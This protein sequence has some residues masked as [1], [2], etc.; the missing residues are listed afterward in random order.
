MTN[1]KSRHD[2]KIST[3]EPKI[4]ELEAK[5]S[6]LIQGWQRTQADFVN[7][8]KRT[9][10]DKERLRQNAKIDTILKILPVVDNFRLSTQHLPAELKN[11]SWAEGITH[12]ERQ[13]EQILSEIGV[14]RIAALGQQF[15]P[16]FHDAI[17]TI[18]SD[19][20]EGEV[21]EESTVGYRLGDQVIRPSRVKVSSGKTQTELHD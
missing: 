19:K 5:N 2:S 7:F 18:P 12:I 16:E 10:E 9:E 17:E 11:N 3:D 13:F 20:P 6:E 8:R 15:N 21:V 4:T 1:K 14:E